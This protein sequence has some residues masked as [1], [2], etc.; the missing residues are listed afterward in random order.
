MTSKYVLPA[1]VATFALAFLVATP[2]VMA[3]SGYGTHSYDGAKSH[4]GHWEIPVGEFVGSIP[5]PEEMDRESHK[6]LDQVTVS[7][8][9]AA[10]DYQNVKKAK[11]GIAVN[12]KGDKF[13]VW[14]LVEFIKDSD[15]ETG[16]M[17][18]YIVDAGDAGIPHVKVTK[19]FDKAT[20]HQKW[21]DYKGMKGHYADM[22]PEEREA[23]FAQHKEMRTAFDSLSEEDQTALKSYFQD[24]KKQF[25]E[26]TEEEMK[27]K[28]AELKEQMQ[29]FMNLPLE[30]KISYLKYLALS[31]RNQA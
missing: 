2:F 9:D 16:T 6:E 25:A 12:D 7:L 22:T 19:D 27:T 5:I 11:L 1:F 8:S 13:L 28:H 29:E 15:S 24:M 26:M 4:K 3:E 31:Q 21:S 23:K 10:A 30:E 20:H 18:I 14:K 17:T